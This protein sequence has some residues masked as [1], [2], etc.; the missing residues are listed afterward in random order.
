M[1]GN[2]EVP[3]EAL[4]DPGVVGKDGIVSPLGREILIP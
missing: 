1:E 3:D 4:V 2:C